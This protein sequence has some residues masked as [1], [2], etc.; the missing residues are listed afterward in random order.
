M[1]DNETWRFVY[2]RK[3]REVP[4]IDLVGEFDGAEEALRQISQLNPDVAIIDFSLSGM[5]GLE[6]AEKMREC[7]DVKVLLATSHS[8]EYLSKINP[9]VFEIFEKGGSVELSDAIRAANAN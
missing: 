1:E 7:S 9:H 5:S 6:L 3:L 4:D 2:R 8:R